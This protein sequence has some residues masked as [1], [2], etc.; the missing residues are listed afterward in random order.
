MKFRGVADIVFYSDC[1]WVVSSFAK[2]RWETTHGGCVAAD[3][4]TAIWDALDDFEFQVR[5]CK[6]KGHARAS[7]DDSS[8]NARY[9]RLG[10]AEADSAARKGARS[11]PSDAAAEQRVVGAFNLAQCVGRFLGRFLHAWPF[12]QQE[13]SRALC[14]RAAP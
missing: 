5:V 4:W 1:Q 9:L 6:V 11:H 12:P 13:R 8:P 7:D 14:S 3:L 10:N 2:G